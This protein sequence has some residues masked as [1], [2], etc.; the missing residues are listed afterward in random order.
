MVALPAAGNRRQRNRRSPQP[1]NR[2][3]A[4]TA[5]PMPTKPQSGPPPASRM[6]GFPLTNLQGQT[7]VSLRPPCASRRPVCAPR[8]APPA[9]PRTRQPFFGDLARTAPAPQATIMKAGGHIGDPGLHRTGMGKGKTKPTGTQHGKEDISE[10]ETPREGATA[11]GAGINGIKTP[12]VAATDINGS[13]QQWVNCDETRGTGKEFEMGAGVGTT[14]VCGAAPLEEAPNVEGDGGVPDHVGPISAT[15]HV[16]TEFPRHGQ[17]R[18]CITHSDDPPNGGAAWGW[19]K[20]KRAPEGGRCCNG[21][22][23]NSA[24]IAESGP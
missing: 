24:C 5:P 7:S 4:L 19:N 22:H 3:R 11:S 1:R 10:M 2:S 9:P 18:Q 16:G 12:R 21:Q 6:L 8:A 23:W 14:H 17:H 15:S 13:K 20:T